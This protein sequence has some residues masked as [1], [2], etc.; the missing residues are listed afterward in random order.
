YDEAEAQA[1]DRMLMCP[2]CPGETIDQAQV[3]L[4]RQMRLR[5]REMLG[6]GASRQ[7]VLDFFVARYGAEV[8]AAPPKSG[9]NLVA[10]VL[11]ALAVPAALA[12]GFFALRAMRRRPDLSLGP[13]P[14]RDAALD[15]FLAK[16]DQELAGGAPKAPPREDAAT[17]G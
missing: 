2:V 13:V 9:F 15:P 12:G 17:H 11:P 4:A 7:E 6:Q 3:E 10:W 8:L 5:V 16:V 14:Q 1:I